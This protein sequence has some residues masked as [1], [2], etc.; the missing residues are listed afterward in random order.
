MSRSHYLS[1]LS[2]SLKWT[3]RH[4]IWATDQQGNRIGC[5]HLLESNLARKCFLWVI[6][7]VEES[8]ITGLGKA[9]R[10]IRCACQCFQFGRRVGY[11]DKAI[12]T[13]TAKTISPRSAFPD[14][15]HP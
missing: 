10:A 14:G 12:F 11:I 7:T 1:A 8:G 6:T 4:Q 5:V 3:F 13:P 2:L 9:D 15:L